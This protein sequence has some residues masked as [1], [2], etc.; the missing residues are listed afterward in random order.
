MRV[1]GDRRVAVAA[2]IVSG[3][4][5]LGATAWLASGR[6][7]DAGTLPSV[8]AAPPEVAEQV[9]LRRGQTL[10]SLFLAASL[11]TDERVDLLSA[12][13]AVAACPSTIRTL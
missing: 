11:S 2:A 5:G 3:I 6:S 4:L 12:F 1:A 13:A 8:A 10:G 7:Y 9:S